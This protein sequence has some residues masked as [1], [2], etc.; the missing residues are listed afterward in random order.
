MVNLFQ[1]KFK[2][3]W[4]DLPDNIVESEGDEDSD[5]TTMLDKKSCVP[6]IIRR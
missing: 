4:L 2:I 1:K 5:E 3:L 6:R